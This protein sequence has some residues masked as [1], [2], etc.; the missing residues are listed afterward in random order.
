MEKPL[1]FV[2]ENKD[3]Q[4]ELNEELLKIIEKSNNPRLLLFYG[5]T[6]QGKSTTL[7]QIIRGNIDTWKYINK[8][9]FKSQTSQKSVTNGCD[10]FGPIKC[11]EIIRRHQLNKNLKEDFDI[12]FCDTEGLFSLNG[13]SRFLIPGILTLLQICTLSV[14]MISSVPD[15]NTISQISSEIQFSKILQQINPELKSPLV[16]IYISGY[17][18]DI[19]G[20]DDFDACINEYQYERDQTSDL[21]LKNMND[22]YPHLNITKRDF[23][24]IPGGP[25]EHNYAEEPDHDSLKAKLYWN[26]IQDIVREFTI[27]CTK[28]KSHSANKLISLMRVVFD[29]F[30]DFK[31]LPNDPDLTNVLIKY[32]NDL[33]NKYS[34]KQFEKISEEIKKDLKNNYEEYYKMLNDDNIAKDKLKTCIEENL[35]DFYKNLIPDKIKNFME[36]AILKLRNSIEIQFEKEYEIKCKE[37]LSKE[38]IDNLIINIKNEINKAHFQED[39]DMNIVKKYTDIWN[40]I[41]KENEKLFIYFNSKKPK[42]IEILKNNFNNTIEKIIQNL[43]SNKIIWKDFF[44]DK[45]RMIQKEINLKYSELFRKIQYQEDFNKLI[46]PSEQLSEELFEKYNEQYFKKLPN[47][48]KDEILTWIK[49]T[50]KNEYNKLKEDNKIK[51]KWKNINQNFS[52]MIKETIN[53]YIQSIF[54]GKQFKNEVE[55]NLGRNDVILNKIPKELINNQEISEDKKQE[56]NNIIKNEVNNAVALFNKKREELPLFEKFLSDKEGLFN[57]IADEKIKEL[58]SKFYYSEDKIPFNA[59]NFFSLIKKNEKMSLNSHQNNES[60]NS[61]INKVSQNKSYEYNNILI[62]KLPSW[63]KI[64]EN[65]KFKIANKCDEFYKKV[66]EN[67]TYKEE[68]NFDINN[69]DSSINSLNLFNGIQQSKHNEIRDLIDK[70]KEKTKKRIINEA[71]SLSKWQD[72]KEILV[73]KGNSIMLNKSETNLNTKDLNQIINILINEVLNYPR[74]LDS[75]KSEKQ[76]NEIINELRIKAEQIGNNY[77]IKTNEKEKKIKE[78]KEE[79][80]RILKEQ[81]EKYEKDKMEKDRIIREEKERAERERIAREKAQREAIEAKERAEREIRQAMEM[82]RQR[83]IAIQNQR[84][85][86][87]F[88]RTPYG[89]NSIVDGLKAIGANSSYGYRAQIAARNGIGGYVGSPDQNLHMLGL[90]KNGNLL[91]P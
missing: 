14:I 2:L 23:K 44:E 35:I 1:P 24:V 36:N 71:N 57:K 20:I 86:Q 78:Q 77:I 46:K 6:R 83:Q 51:P 45:K 13:Q 87:C 9:P 15:V 25:Y 85:Q 42:N 67:K 65:I 12:F 48:K 5:A 81:K 28:N 73:Q 66:V 39:I 74:F 63:N 31:E 90:L 62:P 32:I 43:I 29:I 37:I 26:S 47:N 52:I 38:Y 18:I 41:E 21:I 64:K 82:E 58:M 84:Q 49:N 59:D 80:E 33:F 69:L 16:T 4:L 53:N 54:N 10:I 79:H 11:S 72:K 75:C 30:K 88:P 61:L 91:R 34:I 70:L 50:C 7:N 19:V 68:I 27:Y 3:H 89:G 60:F 76:K 56:I 17:Q 55:P 8:S 40:L 22:N